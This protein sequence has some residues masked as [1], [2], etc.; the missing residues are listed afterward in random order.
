LWTTE[1]E[2]FGEVSGEVLST[3]NQRPMRNLEVSLNA[4]EEPNVDQSW[5]TSFWPLNVSSTYNL[6]FVPQFEVSGNY[7]NKTLSLNATHASNV[8]EYDVHNLYAHAM[9]QSMFEQ[10]ATQFE[11]SRPF[12]VSRGSYASSGKYTS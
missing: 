2:P 9:M 10:Y 4:D 12:L 8:Q 1:N 6:P 5:F 3:N 7:D 11:D